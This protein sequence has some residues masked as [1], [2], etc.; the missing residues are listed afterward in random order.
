MDQLHR[1]SAENASAKLD[2]QKLKVPSDKSTAD[3][4]NFKSISQI[5]F[6]IF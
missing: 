1:L 3:S 4:H 2:N 5:L 6:E